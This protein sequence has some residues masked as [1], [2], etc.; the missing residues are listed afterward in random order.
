MGGNL[1]ET[2]RMWIVAELMRNGD[3]ISATRRNWTFQGT[4]FM[5]YEVNKTHLKKRYTDPV[6][7][8]HPKN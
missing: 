8:L 2:E 1:T 5:A 7:S 6:T 3:S 4:I